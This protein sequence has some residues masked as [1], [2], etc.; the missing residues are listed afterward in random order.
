ME[1]KLELAL[2]FVFTFIIG[3]LSFFIAIS[4]NNLTFLLF[5][6]LFAP[7]ISALILTQFSDGGFKNVKNLFQKYFDKI[8]KKKIYFLAFF[9]IPFLFFFAG[10]VSDFL[11][12]NFNLIFT[13]SPW[14]FIII[15]FIYLLFITSGEEIGWRGYALPRLLKQNDDWLVMSLLLGIIWGLWHLPIYLI[16]GQTNSNFT[17]PLF[18]LF[19]IGIT[20]IYTF[21]YRNTDESL[22]SVTIFHA[23]SDIMPRILLFS[24]LTNTFWYLIVG[25]TWVMMFALYYI[26]KRM[27]YKLIQR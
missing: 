21:I 27:K 22:L 26:N 17:Y 19:T 25:L 14:Y 5:L 9:L 6:Y 20:P 4:F 13:G 3:W 7:A 12:N 16:S 24:S 15:S 1:L 10:I 18:L 2:F 23:S 11:T 8:I